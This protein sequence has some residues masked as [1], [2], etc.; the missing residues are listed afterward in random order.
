MAEY[1]LGIELPRFAF[2]LGIMVSLVIYERRHLST[3]SLIVPGYIAIYALQPLTIAVTL[4]NALI[5]RWVV[6][7]VLA[8]RVVLY[9]RDRITAL[10]LVSITLQSVF[11]TLTP[12]G[13]YL[14]AN[15]LPFLV[16]VGY[17]VPAMI[18]HDM[19]RQGKGKTLG[20]VIVAGAIVAI[21]VLV[22][23]ALMPEVIRAAPLPGDAA[24]AIS[25]RWI[26]LAVL[27]SAAA[28]WALLNNLGWRAGGF[29]GGAYVAMLAVTAAQVWFIVIISVLTWLIVTRV[30]VQH[31]IVFGR[32]KFGTMLLTSSFLA[33]TIM[34]MLAPIGAA[35]PAALPLVAIALSPLFLPGLIANDME[36][37]GAVRTLAG[38]AL[39]AV[40]VFSTVTTLQGGLEA[41]LVP[42]PWA[43]AALAT[44]LVIFHR[45]L[46][47]APRF[48]FGRRQAGPLRV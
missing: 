21:P 11:L 40:F 32:R 27:L 18:A 29:V 13:P 5:A 23:A 6:D 42:P 19:A 37:G 10:A 3:G 45:Q 24:F 1:L 25:L 31:S 38:T 48:V 33:W 41:G 47:A 9:G 2:V 14:W 22:A 4:I 12:A 30:F 7:D 36:R 34:T 43:I 39:S 26:P 44:G 46:V 15:D 8:R 20:V 17:V 16:G 28:S 35:A